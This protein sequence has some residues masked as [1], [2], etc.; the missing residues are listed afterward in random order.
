MPRCSRNSSAK[1]RSQSSNSTTS[2]VS[3]A[4]TSSSATAGGPWGGRPLPRPAPPRPAGPALD[5]AA[6]CAAAATEEA[7]AARRSW[8]L[9]T[10]MSWLS[11]SRYLSA[12][13][14]CSSGNLRRIIVTRSLK[15]SM[16]GTW[17]M[18]VSLPRVTFRVRGCTGLRAWGAAAIA[19]ACA[20]LFCTIIWRALARCFLV[21][22]LSDASSRVAISCASV[23]LLPAS[24]ASLVRERT[25]VRAFW[26][27]PFS[28]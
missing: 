27:S 18:R 5:A 8:R 22:F 21:V 14:P 4:R 3:S 28:S 16:P 24:S 13:W 26:R 12:S 9:V 23:R 2:S 7:T 19:C 6:A 25:S 10:V 15:G 11:R 17:T 20:W 1:S